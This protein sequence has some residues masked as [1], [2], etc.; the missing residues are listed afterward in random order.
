MLTRNLG[1]TGLRVSALCLGGNTFGW[2][3]D[4][5]ASEAVLDAY[6]EAGGN[7]IDTAD[8]Y[9]RWVPGNS[10]GESEAALGQWMAARKNRQAVVIATKVMGPMGPGPNDTG[11]SRQHIAAGVE[12]SLRRLQ[13][14]YIDLYQAHWDDRQTPLDETLRAFDDLV[15]QGRVR[16][17][18]CSNYVAWRL[19]RALWE[20]DKRGL[21]RYESLQPKYNLV[22]R[23]EYE[24]ELEPLCLEQGVGVIPYSTLGSGFL[25]GKYRRGGA[26]PM[27]ARAGGVQKTYMTDRGFGVLDAVEQVAAKTG[28]TPAQVSLSWLAHRPGITAPIASAT[29]PAQLKE[30]VGGIELRL[31]DEA[32]ATLDRASAWREA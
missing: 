32:T 20:A 26:L 27:T 30:L 23:D 25:T 5:P 11:L 22:F 12:A 14:D 21:V 3:T 15:R 17:V 10:G 2:T 13:T 16:Y 31:D 4:Q 9:A 6:V 29:S 7:F 18:G 19:T 8:V 1:R 28:A 24:R